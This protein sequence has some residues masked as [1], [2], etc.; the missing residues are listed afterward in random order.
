MSRT[1]LATLTLCASALCAVSAAA[2]PQ[3]S[4]V[5]P[6]HGATSGGTVIT[7]SGAQ[8]SATGNSASVGANPCPITTEGP[9]QIECTL[10]EGSGAQRPVRV[11][12]TNGESSPPYPFH[13]DPPEVTD[14]LP[15]NG[16]T[17][18]GVI[19]TII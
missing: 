5:T 19:I 15:A 11:S 12:D 3:I 1:L 2:A 9:E 13:Y 18:G 6:S 8:F 10:P 4:D 14:V 16:K 7:I 17:A